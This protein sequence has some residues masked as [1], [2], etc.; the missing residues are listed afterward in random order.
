MAIILPKEGSI[1]ETLGAGIGSGLQALA[2][3]KIQ[4]M[5]KHS[6]ANSLQQMGLAPDIAYLPEK[7]QPLA[8]KQ[9]YKGIEALG[10]QAQNQALFEQGIQLGG[11]PDMLR[12]AYAAGNL[13]EQVN[14][15]TNAENMSYAQRAGLTSSKTN[16]FRL[17]P[18]R[19][20][21]NRLASEYSG[22]SG[23]QAL[24]NMGTQLSPQSQVSASQGFTPQEQTLMNLLEDPN[25]PAE[26]KQEAR[27]AI[28]SVKGRDW[29][30]GIGALA[31]SAGNF[32]SNA[33]STAGGWPSQ[34]ESVLAPAAKFLSAPVVRSEIADLKAQ[35]EKMEK[36][37]PEYKKAQDRINL[38]QKDLDAPITYAAPSSAKVKED[39]VRPLAKA[40][41]V[42]KHI[43]PKNPLETFFGRVGGVA[44]AVVVSSLLGGGP[45]AANLLRQS[46]IAGL[47]EGSGQLTEAITGS[48]LGGNV[49]SLLGYIIP[50]LVKPGFFK[51]LI[52]DGYKSFEKFIKG[53]PHVKIDASHLMEELQPVR[54]AVS[55]D[56][57]SSGY[58]FLTGRLGAIEN[59]LGG[60]RD[61]VA[62]PKKLFA[63]D[64]AF[65][66]Q[67]DQAEKLGVSAE[68]QQMREAL[69]KAYQG[70]ASGV[71]PA[72]TQGLVS[73]RAAEESL[74]S[75]ST[76]EKI[77]HEVGETKV[78]LLSQLGYTLK[79]VARALKYPA[80]MGNL[81][82]K[83][84]MMRGEMNQ[85]LKAAA[86]DNKAG[87]YESAGKIYNVLKNKK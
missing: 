16:Q 42:E 6:Y 83:N 52:S 78:P 22:S 49:A 10:K 37:S 51:G 56:P 41:G 84:P 71:D 11:D 53:N 85:L 39:F 34:L 50:G 4:Q 33:V 7:L 80:K 68:F 75:R 63:L 8:I 2:Q 47:A 54:E 12:Q 69:R 13:K 67:Y 5:Q 74:R 23:V 18:E 82:W 15:L 28:Q 3:G 77:L 35:A 70:W 44:P 59:S 76:L 17:S 27:E 60:L 31:G 20:Q 46:K 9:H 25:V 19:Q 58:K 45:V 48:K 64:Q 55:V 65:G 30:Y 79:F 61:R 24:N 72:V 21:V 43:D 38:L 1:Y 62:S 14:K 40:L 87:M 29:G 66:K 73:A 36:G 26:K 81:W 32:L 57:T 86:N